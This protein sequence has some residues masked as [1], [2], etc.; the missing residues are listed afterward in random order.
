METVRVHRDVWVATRGYELRRLN[1]RRIKYPLT[2]AWIIILA[3][4]RGISKNK[5]LWDPEPL[6]ITA[7]SSAYLIQA[8]NSKFQEILADYRQKGLFHS[9]TKRYE[10]PGR[11]FMDFSAGEVRIDPGEAVKKSW[12]AQSCKLLCC[13]FEFDHLQGEIFALIS[14]RRHL[15]LLIRVPAYHFSKM[16]CFHS[17]SVSF[18]HRFLHR[19]CPCRLPILPQYKPR[20]SSQVKML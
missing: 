14:L 1:R 4:H 19:N 7:A 5:N 2:N 16:C 20:M 8:Q 15:D 10:P 12:N 13:P 11:K 18:L 6:G 3:F 17:W 9:P